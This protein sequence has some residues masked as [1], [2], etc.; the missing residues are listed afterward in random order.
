MH[1]IK[2]LV[3]AFLFISILSWSGVQAFSDQSE[4][5]DWAS[6]AIDFLAEK[7]ILTGNAD[8][9]FAPAREINRAE[10]CKM[11]VL[12]TESEIFE[13]AT[14]SFPDVQ[15]SDWFFGPVETAK[16]LG[17]ISGYPDGTFGP[18]KNINR[19]EVAK[20][21]SIAFD[22]QTSEN[23]SSD[24]WFAGYFDQM[25]AKNLLGHGRSSDDLE[26]EGFPS[27]SEIAEQLVRFLISSGKIDPAE[28]AGE[29]MEMEE[30]KEVAEE[31]WMELELAPDASEFGEVAESILSPSDSAGKLE[32]E[33]REVSGRIFDQDGEVWLEGGMENVKIH[34]LRLTPNE[35]EVQVAALQFR[36]IGKGEMSDF[37]AIWVEKNGEQ[38]SEKIEPKS[39]LVRIEFDEIHSISRATDFSLVADLGANISDLSARFV[40]YLPSWIDAD[41]D[42]KIGFFPLAGPDL[43]RHD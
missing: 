14:A 11:L 43:Y 42:S 33:S 41:T 4:I 13:P 36:R 10:F 16:N 22:L 12:A 38:I 30:I 17:W 6:S 34:E 29:N 15:P 35:G 2:K 32:V 37:A 23:A 24:A 31:T 28:I 1:A 20:I 18:A 25:N 21:L 8:G 5:P 3:S 27:R 9:S 26:A 7:N 39:D 19:A 40:L